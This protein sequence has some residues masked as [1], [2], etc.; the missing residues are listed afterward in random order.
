MT[1]DRIYRKDALSARR[2]AREHLKSLRAARLS[3][4]ES[5]D[6][7]TAGPAAFDSGEDDFAMA[8]DTLFSGTTSGADLL[9]SPGPVETVPSTPPTD[10]DSTATS[11]ES[12]P[13]TCSAPDDA[14]SEAPADLGEVDEESGKDHA[15]STKPGEPDQH[16]EMQSSGD[17]A[18]QITDATSGDKAIV[19]EAS[20]S[21]EVTSGKRDLVSV[22]ELDIDSDLIQLPGA[23]SGM[24]WMFNQCGVMSLRDL[25]GAKPG[26]LSDKLGVVGRILDVA[27][28]IEYAKERSISE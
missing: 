11:R 14:S 20:E 28:W 27:P 6:R 16:A 4:R 25:A 19:P 17:P 12:D 7:K 3:R 22:A 5:A 9:G 15:I 18:D 1:S 21:G 2:A 10:S 23:G 24:V 26:E 8:P 13:E